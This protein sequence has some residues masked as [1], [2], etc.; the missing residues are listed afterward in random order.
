MT[1]GDDGGIYDNS[2]QLTVAVNKVGQVEVKFSNGHVDMMWIDT[3][4][5]VNAVRCLVQPLTV[6]TLQRNGAKQNHHHQ[7]QPPHLVRLPQAVDTPHFTLLVGVAEDARCMTTTRCDAVDEVFS[8]I[9]CNVL[10]QL[11]Q[12]PRRPFLLRIC[13]LQLHTHRTSV[14]YRTHTVH[15]AYTFV[16]SQ[17]VQ[18]TSFCR[19]QRGHNYSQPWNATEILI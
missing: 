14:T 7:V 6:C 2:V 5:R 9:L 16:Y 19:E 18:Q 13:L 3:E 10:P 12:Q 1:V 15:I 17:T 4:R 8:A 11:R